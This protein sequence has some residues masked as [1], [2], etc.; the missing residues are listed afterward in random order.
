VAWQLW[1]APAEHLR[2]L[3]L[4]QNR[5][6]A[7]TGR[8]LLKSAEVDHR[9]PLFAVWAEHR[10]RTWP[11]LLTFWGA[12]N[13][14]VINKAAHLEKCAGEAAERSQRRVAMS[15]PVEND[16]GPSIVKADKVCPDPF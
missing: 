8:R 7:S 15:D 13:L 16:R 11:E 6:C 14:Q 5:K 12:P 1:T 3:K 10:A 4:R 9:V 2:T